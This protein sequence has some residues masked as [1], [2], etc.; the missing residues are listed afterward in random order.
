MILYC[1]KVVLLLVA[2]IE[3]RKYWYDILPL[4]CS[5]NEPLYIV[6]NG[7]FKFKI[8]ALFIFLE[9]LTGYN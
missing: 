3:E 5:N 6:I 2:V 9:K 4:M 8:R 1:C 7:T